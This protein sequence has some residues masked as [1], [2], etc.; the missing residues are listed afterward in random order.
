MMNDL[1]SNGNYGMVDNK[2]NK[3]VNPTFRI[4]K[5]KELAVRPLRQTN[6]NNTLYNVTDTYGYSAPSPNPQM[7]NPKQHKA[8]ENS[9]NIKVDENFGKR[10][11]FF[12]F[13]KKDFR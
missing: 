12:S 13:E 10:V 11:I 4:Q 8:K 9:F 2:N 6:T 1:L 3:M 5:N 7:N